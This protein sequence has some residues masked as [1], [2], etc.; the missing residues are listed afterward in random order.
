MKVAGHLCVLPCTQGAWE[1]RGGGQP[2]TS[3]TAIRVKNMQVR[4]DL[5][6]P[7]GRSYHVVWVV[8]L[9]C[10]FQIDMSTAENE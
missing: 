2:S 10:L 7:C 4:S 3:V 1:H 8:G 6:I 5:V 9:T